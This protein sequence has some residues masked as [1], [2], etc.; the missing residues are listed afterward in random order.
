MGDVG[1]TLTIGSFGGY[2]GARE[3]A[4]RNSA[5]DYYTDL[6]ELGGKSRSMTVCVARATLRPPYR[7]WQTSK[8]QVRVLSASGAGVVVVAGNPQMMT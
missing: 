6:H 8:S 4:V 3:A 7:W 2:R 5:S 1:E